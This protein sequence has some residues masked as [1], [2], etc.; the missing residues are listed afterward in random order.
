MFKGKK[1]RENEESDWHSIPLK[2][3]QQPHCA[4]ACRHL[5]LV[6][7]ALMGHRHVSRPCWECDL[8]LTVPEKDANPT[9]I[10]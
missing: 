10:I 2:M 7:D 5:S 3:S 6:I 1:G 9:D 8:L 4:C